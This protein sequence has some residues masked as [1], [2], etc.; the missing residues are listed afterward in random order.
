MKEYQAP[1]YLAKAATLLAAT[2]LLNGCGNLPVTPVDPPQSSTTT[3]T[4][5]QQTT[6]AI[7]D[8]ETSI[9][10]A[11]C[12]SSVVVVVE[13]VVVVVGVVVSTSPASAVCVGSASDGCPLHPPSTVATASRAAAFFR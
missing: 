2:T 7:S 1:A 9:S 5:I 11:N 8:S 10:P 13:V 12:S 3:Q 6:T 4:T